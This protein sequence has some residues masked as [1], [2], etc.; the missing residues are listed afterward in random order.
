MTEP[1]DEGME[2]EEDRF[3]FEF[4]L[5]GLILTRN[6]DLQI[7]SRQMILNQVLLNNRAWT[8]V[9]MELQKHQ[10]LKLCK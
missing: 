2:V 3:V 1:R 9:W 8:T 4:I 10:I 7:S 6:V 5:Y